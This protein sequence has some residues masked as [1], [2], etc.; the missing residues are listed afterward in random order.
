M[1]TIT[2]GNLA[3]QTGTLGIAGRLFQLLL[4]L[5]DLTFA[6][7]DLLFEVVQ[8]PASTVLPQ[9][10]RFTFAATYITVA[11]SGTPHLVTMTWLAVT[12]YTLLSTGKIGIA[13]GIDTNLATGLGM[14]L[15][16]CPRISGKAV[17]LS[18]LIPIRATTL[19]L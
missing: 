19:V 2:V 11:F 3:A 8:L 17:M 13:I 7:P 5:A 6:T 12:V 9:K 1:L 10:T 18:Q 16:P 14:F 4:Q 15:D